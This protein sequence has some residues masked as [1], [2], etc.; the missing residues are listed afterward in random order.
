MIGSLSDSIAQSGDRISPTLAFVDPFGFSGVPMEL[1]KRFLDAPKCELVLTLMVDHLNRFLNEDS[2]RES[3]D[4]LY[5]TTDF[6][7]IIAAPSGQRIPCLVDKYESQLREFAG[8]KYTRD[9]Q[10]QRSNGSVAYYMVYATRNELG[11]EKFKEAMW[12]IDPSTGYRFSDR[13]WRQAALFTG[14]NVDVESLK[15]RL[16]AEYSGQTITIE[17]LERFTLHETPYVKAHLRQKTLSPLERRGNI[18][19]VNPKPGRRA[20]QYPPGT[21]LEFQ[22]SL[23]I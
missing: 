9:F 11:V 3:R 15:S 21:L 23:G 7:D 17:E 8:F 4:D 12:K 18:T 20:G 13:S 22:L 14:E 6:T 10:M 2:I 1:I 16:L 5:G 19:V